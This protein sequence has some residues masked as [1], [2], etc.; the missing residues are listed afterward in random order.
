MVRWSK[1]AAVVCFVVLANAAGAFAQEQRGSIEG[2]VKDSTGGVLPGVTIEARSPAL[3]GTASV[4]SD[5]EGV[6]RFPALAPGVYTVT[7]A[8]QGFTTGRVDNV[9]LNLGQVLRVTL[10]LALG[11][12]S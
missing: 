7:G 12:L 6:F 1:L 2:V 5:A 10:T 9:V 8:L 11:G 3:V 4:T